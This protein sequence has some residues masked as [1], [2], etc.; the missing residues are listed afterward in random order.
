MAMGGVSYLLRK[1]NREVLQCNFQIDFVTNTDIIIGSALASYCPAVRG[2]DNKLAAKLYVF[3]TEL[4]K[5]TDHIEAWEDVKLSELPSED[6]SVTVTRSGYFTVEA[7]KFSAS[8]K[9]WAIVTAQTELPAEEVENEKGEQFAQTQTVGGDLLIGQNK[10]VTAGQAFTP[11]Y[12]TAK[13]EIFDRT[14]WKDN[15]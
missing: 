14:V 11:I 9:S 12:F 3:P 2:I 8:G 6:I 15:L 1:D 4:N 10:E 7:E 13:H 5:F